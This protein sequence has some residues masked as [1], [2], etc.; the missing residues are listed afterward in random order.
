MWQV[1]RPEVEHS[2]AGRWALVAILLGAGPLV[3]GC[4]NGYPIAATRC[5]R[6]CDLAQE[7]WCGDYNP[8]SCVVSCEESRK[9]PACDEKLDALLRCLGDHEQEIACNE[10]SYGEFL[11]CKDAANA[12]LACE[13]QPPPRASGSAE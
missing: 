10:R 12:R 11:P 5:D 13:M 4:Q 6:L 3:A 1:R 7:T 2:K 8:A 9:N